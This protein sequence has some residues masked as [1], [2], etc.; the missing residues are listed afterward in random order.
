MPIIGI[1]IGRCMKAFELEHANLNDCIS[2]AQNEPVVITRVGTPVA[3]I[4][5]VNGL[6]AEQIELGTSSEFWK[7]IQARRAEP[8]ISREELENRIAAP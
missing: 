5:P 4:V 8:T 2:A 1:S 7:L 3:L 6:D